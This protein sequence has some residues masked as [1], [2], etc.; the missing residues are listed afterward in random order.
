MDR[1]KF[2]KSAT[3]ALAY[4]ACGCAAQEKKDIDKNAMPNILFIMT[5]QQHAGMMSCT[6]NKW[7][8]TPAMDSLARDGIRFEKA[9]AANPVCVPSRTSMATG[10]MPDRLGA[11]NNGIGMKIRTLAEEKNWPWEVGLLTNPDAE[12]I[13]TE[14]IVASADSA[15]LDKCSRWTNLADYIIKKLTTSTAAV[16]IVDLSTS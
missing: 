9:Y 1:R 12:L 2:I 7:L 6:G 15:V 5:D 4:A 16:K 14:L 10:V 3:S 11:G 13:K 8:K